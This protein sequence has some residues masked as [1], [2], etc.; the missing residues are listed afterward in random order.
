LRLSLVACP[1]GFGKT[2][3]LAAWRE[4]EAV[5]RPV[6]WLTVDEGDNDPVVE[7]ASPS[8]GRAA[9]PRRAA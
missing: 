1:A 3:L 5:R 8:V 2:T 9:R 7:G 4:V 6:A